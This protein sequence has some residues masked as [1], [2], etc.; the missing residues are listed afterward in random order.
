MVKRIIALFL[1]LVTATMIFCS[2]SKKQDE[3]DPSLITSY[4]K[5]EGVK[6]VSKV[7]VVAKGKETGEKV[8]IEIEIGKKDKET[9]K[10]VT[11]EKKLK[12]DNYIIKK[13]YTNDK[14]VSVSIKEQYF[15]INGQNKT[16]SFTL[17]EET[18]M[19][20][21]EWFLRNNSFYL[22]LLVGSCVFLGVIKFRKEKAI[23]G[24]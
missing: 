8:K 7:Y 14:R 4:F 5:L 15:S 6:K 3:N 13:V 9:G 20:N 1:L 23:R 24:R 12:A 19:G 18:E 16:I 22:I 21:L 17:M 11:T 2:C 10:L